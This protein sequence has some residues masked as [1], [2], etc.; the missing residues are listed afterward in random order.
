MGRVGGAGPLASGAL[1]PTDASA[2]MFRVI[3]LW[4]PHRVA[5]SLEQPW[6]HSRWFITM[7]TSMGC[8]A[9]LAWIESQLS[10]FLAK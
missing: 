9:R 2:S 3:R 4:V 10:C 7:G 5:S 1:Q 8:G 6:T